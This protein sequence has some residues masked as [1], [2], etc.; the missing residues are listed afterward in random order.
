[1]G[2]VPLGLYS[3]FDALVRLNIACDQLHKSIGMYLPDD[4]TPTRGYDNRSRAEI[5]PEV[6]SYLMLFYRRPQPCVMLTKAASGL[7]V[8]HIRPYIC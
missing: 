1:M 3:A 2:H 6:A 5:C 4:V 7:V 8:S